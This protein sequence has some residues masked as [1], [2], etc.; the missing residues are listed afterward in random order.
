MVVEVVVV[1]DVVVGG[2]GVTLRSSNRCIS[3]TDLLRQLRIE[4]AATR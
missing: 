1:A 4:F 2:G 3:G